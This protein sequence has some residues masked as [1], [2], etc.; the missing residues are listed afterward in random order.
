MQHLN[1]GTVV[2]VKTIVIDGTSSNVGR[3][4]GAAIGG[5][6]GRTVGSGDGTV[7]ATA[8]G[9]AAGVVVGPMVEKELTK[10]VAQEVTIDLDDGHVIVV[11]QETKDGGFFEGDRVEVMESITG[12]ARIRHAEFESDGLYWN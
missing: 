2:S 11:V 12:V 10:K 8:V 1:G 7:L 6:I 5:G 3:A 4:A 9:V